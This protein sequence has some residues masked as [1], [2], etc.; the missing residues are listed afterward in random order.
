[1]RYVWSWDPV[2][3]PSS[4]IIG[5]NEESTRLKTGSRSICRGLTI[6]KR[7][8]RYVSSIK[9]FQEEGRFSISGAIS[10][11]SY[12]RTR[13]IFGRRRGIEPACAEYRNTF[14]IGILRCCRK[15]GFPAAVR[16]RDPFTTFRHVPDIVLTEVRRILARGPLVVQSPNLHS[17][18]ASLTKGS[19][20]APG[21]STTSRRRRSRG[22]SSRAASRSGS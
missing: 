7:Y 10:A 21:P 9:R 19:G 4:N 6:S 11:C 17:L 22:S 2:P 15:V 18:M 13:R 1:M 16:C 3:L 14:K 20:S 5:T 8:R 12:G